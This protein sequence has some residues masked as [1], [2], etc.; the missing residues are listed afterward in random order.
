MDIHSSYVVN[1]YASATINELDGLFLEK[2]SLSNDE[3]VCSNNII[4]FC[5]LSTFCCT[6]KINQV[7]EISD[8]RKNG[9]EIY[10]DRGG[11][12]RL[13]LC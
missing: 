3:S 8:I 10:F 13:V 5:I 7:L 2:L 11:S 1:Y 4:Y 12:C 6:T 9:L